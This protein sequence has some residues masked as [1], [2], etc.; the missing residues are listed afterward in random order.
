MRIFTGKYKKKLLEAERVLDKIA[1][2]KQTDWQTVAAM[3]YFGWTWD[4]EGKAI[5][6]GES[7]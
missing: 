6:P 3:R 4:S 7:K 5:P 1:H 2:G